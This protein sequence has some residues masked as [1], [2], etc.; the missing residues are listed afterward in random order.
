[1]SHRKGLS[2]KAALF[3]SP[4]PMNPDP[5]SLRLIVADMD[6]TLLDSAHQL[7]PDFLDVL[8]DLNKKDILFAVAS[9]RQF[10]NLRDCFSEK[11]P[12][13]IYI[14]ENGAYVQHNNK[15]LLVNTLDYSLVSE[16]LEHSARH[17]VLTPVVCGVESA[18]TTGGDK[19]FMKLLKTYFSRIEILSELTGIQDRILKVTFYDPEGAENHGCPLFR[20]FEPLVSIKAGSPIWVDITATGVN[21]GR[22]VQ[23]VQEIYQILPP[24]RIQ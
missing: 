12:G 6:G 3:F 19:N 8:E 13:M 5:H 11:F 2:E 16:I 17:P 1:M 15:E 24:V 10:A 7:P 18:Y 20:L 4:L 21:K 23:K 14:A 9:G 22:A